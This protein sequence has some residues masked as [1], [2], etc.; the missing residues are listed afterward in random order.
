MNIL[1]IS[2]DIILAIWA[3]R[4]RQ[5]KV[6][7]IPE[8]RMANPVANPN[9]LAIAADQRKIFAPTAAAITGSDRY[10]V[11]RLIRR[12]RKPTKRIRSPLNTEISAEPAP[13][14]LEEKS[15]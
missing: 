5:P 15:D 9:E 14:I 1:G 8:D 10:S 7:S 11:N 12:A 2:R 13:M 6:N 3:G 4:I